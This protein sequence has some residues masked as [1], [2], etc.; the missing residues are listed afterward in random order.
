MEL[1]FLLSLQSLSLGMK[2]PNFN[3]SYILSAVVACYTTLT[4]LIGLPFQFSLF[5]ASLT[6]GGEV[7]WLPIKGRATEKVSVVQHIYNPSTNQV[8]ASCRCWV[9]HLGQKSCSSRKKGS[10]MN[11]AWIPDIEKRKGSRK[12]PPTHFQR[13]TTFVNPQFLTKNI[14]SQL[15]DTTQISKVYNYYYFE[16][17]LKSTLRNTLP[18]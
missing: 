4:F 16:L 6:C 14:W 2:Y 11:S 9:P 3:A 5:T 8:C 1:S 7:D 13:N 15:N 17:F 10:D 12:M 18:V